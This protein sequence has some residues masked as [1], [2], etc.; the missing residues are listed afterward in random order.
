MP[1]A[2]VLGSPIAHSLSPALHRA[3]YSAL[4]LT[5]WQYDAVECDESG[6][7]RFLDGLGPQ[8]VGLSLTMPLKRAVLGLVDTV[9][10][11]VREV[12]AA[13]TVLLSP[14]G[15]HAENTDVAG[16]VDALAGVDTADPVV[17]GAGGTAAAAMAAIRQLGGA[18]V[19]VVVRDPGRARDLLAAAA[20]L[21][22]PVQL[23]RWPTL[24]ESATVVVSTVP[25]GAADRLAGHGWRSAT[26][27]CDLVYD[28]WP[29]PLTQA[30]AAAGCRV[31]GGR[32][33]LLHQA[34]RQVRL[35]TGRPPPLAAM[36][37]AVALT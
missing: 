27:V 23:L 32:D 4:G 16:L 15:R 2:A 36:R 14:A 1:R 31:V 20:R 35:M 17:L 13:N 37:A 24:P 3:A 18:G 25:S 10:D 7:G 8:W 26:T 28:P 5:D 30:A 9:S 11:L 34:A 29:T 33:V 6:L 12:G 22:V 21:G 19:R